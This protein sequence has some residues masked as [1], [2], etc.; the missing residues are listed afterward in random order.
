[1][2]PYVRALKN[3]DNEIINR[4]GAALGQIGDRDAMGPLIEALITTHKVKV[5]EGNADQHAY[6]FS[7]DSGSFSFGGGGPKV[8]SQDLRNPAV[9]NAL[10]TLSGG[11]SFDYD[12]AGWRRWLAAQAKKQAID[13][14]R[15][16]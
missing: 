8:I 13:I 9:L 4:A 11:T 6:S 7:P 15:D 10:V 2:T 1:V 14:R 16:E 12:Q 5:A 3:R